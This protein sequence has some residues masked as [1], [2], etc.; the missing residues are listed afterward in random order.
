MF[1]VWKSANAARRDFERRGLHRDFMKSRG[2]ALETKWIDRR[3]KEFQGD[4]QICARDPSDT[5][6]RALDCVAHR[7][8]R[9]LDPPVHPNRDERAQ[10]L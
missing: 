3:T 5:V 6:A 4:M 9:V 7:G 10:R 8:D 2:E 1:E